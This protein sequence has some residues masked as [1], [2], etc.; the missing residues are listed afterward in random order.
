M[1]STFLVGYL[2]LC[3][4]S[5]PVFMILAVNAPIVEHDL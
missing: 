4:T 3:A 5:L 1:L 2:I